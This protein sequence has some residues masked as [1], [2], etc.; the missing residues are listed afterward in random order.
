MK[1]RQIIF[2][3]WI[4]VWCCACDPS[5]YLL[6]SNR[7]GYKQEIWV[8]A[9]TNMVEF[10]EAGNGMFET[11]R[12]LRND[13]LPGYR[14]FVPLSLPDCQAIIIHGRG[15]AQPAGEAIVVGSD[16]IDARDFRLKKSVFGSYKWGYLIE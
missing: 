9:H 5:Y 2:M 10:Y 6:I 15:I 4:T 3:A 16:T 8:K 12:F 1:K 14:A 11:G 7:S 13:T